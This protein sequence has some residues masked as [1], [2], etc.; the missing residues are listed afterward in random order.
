MKRKVISTTL[1]PEEI[2]QK[3]EEILKSLG[4]TAQESMEL[5]ES[6][7]KKAEIERSKEQNK[8]N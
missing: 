4:I 8:V 3:G 5:F 2:K 7:I 1:T 6:D